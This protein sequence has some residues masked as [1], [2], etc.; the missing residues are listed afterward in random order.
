MPI[1]FKT[2]EERNPTQ[3]VVTPEI[4]KANKKYNTAETIKIEPKDYS[5]VEI[6]PYTPPADAKSGMYEEFD[7]VSEDDLTQTPFAEGEEEKLALDFILEFGL[8][9]KFLL[10]CG[11]QDQ[12]KKLKDSLDITIE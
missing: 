6:P 9:N 2:E 4:I 3:P 7:I 10:W 12:L 5:N 1:V 11:I 8:Y